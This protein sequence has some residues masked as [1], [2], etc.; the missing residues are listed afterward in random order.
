MDYF[1][2]LKKKL[3]DLGI[4]GLDEKKIND[5]VEYS[6]KSVPKEFIPKTKY[7]ETKEELDAAGKKLEETNKTIK[8]LQGKET[9]LED[10]KTKLETLNTEYDTFKSDAEK[11]VD[12]IKKKSLIKDELLKNG[13]DPANVDLLMFEFNYY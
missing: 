9:D 6:K 3:T 1:D 4:E 2:E 13:A 11:R 8:D 5:V 10:Y 7:N 12:N